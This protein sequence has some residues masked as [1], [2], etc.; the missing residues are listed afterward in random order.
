MRVTTGRII[1]GAV[2]CG[3]LVQAAPVHGSVSSRTPATTSARVGTAATGRSPLVGRAGLS[4]AEP[5]KAPATLPALSTTTPLLP[6]P[7]RA[8]SE[9][10]RRPPAFAS[11]SLLLRGASLDSAL[12]PVGAMS[13]T[14]MTV[15]AS[16]TAAEL[17][18]VTP[19]PATDALTP[20]VATT[21]TA[22]PCATAPVTPTDAPTASPT[23]VVMLPPS[24][25]SPVLPGLSPGMGAATPGGGTFAPGGGNGHGDAAAA[26]LSCYNALP[27]SFEPNVGQTD[28]KAAFLVRAPG[29][30][31][32]LTA[33]DLML[34]LV[35]SLHA[36]AHA[37]L[38]AALTPVVASSGSVLRTALCRG[39]R[40]P[41]A[42]RPRSV[43]GDR[44]LSARERREELA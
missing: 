34:K 8:P 40:Q 4:S 14:G 31:V 43:A 29:S 3:L 1:A 21:A 42:R 18:L 5:G 44:Q 22:P 35:T 37:S 11:A 41:A 15:P 39:K 26:A 33:S 19:R 32:F 2:L 23:S 7:S 12:S 36:P 30:T 25:P 16:L 17:P 27:L 6:P 28:H 13:E 24:T 20:T 10:M 9:G 38:D